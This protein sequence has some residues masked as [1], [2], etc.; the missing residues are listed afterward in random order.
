M[1]YAQSSGTVIMYQ[2]ERVKD[3]EISVRARWIKE[4]QK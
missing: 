1:F 3:P 4:T 2:G